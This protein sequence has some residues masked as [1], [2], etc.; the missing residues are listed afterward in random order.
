MGKGTRLKQEKRARVHR[1]AGGTL[2]IGGFRL[3]AEMAVALS[4]PI[5]SVCA[6]TQKAV[7]ATDRFFTAVAN[8]VWRLRRKMTDAE[9]GEAK[10]GFGN[11]F[12][13][14]EALADAL[15]EQGI[16]TRDHDGERYDPGMALK[17]IASEPRRGL[18]REEII[19]T[20]KP[21]IRTKDG[22]LQIGEVIVGIPETES[23]K[24]ETN[25][26]QHE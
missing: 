9:T 13:H 19:E 10:D 17:V 21:T 16:E 11:V 22:I 23:S 12:R 3:S 24:S 14:V 20:V 6:P 25:E 15:Q 4:E 8:N 26:T 5:A 18:I 2:G 7:T 1:K